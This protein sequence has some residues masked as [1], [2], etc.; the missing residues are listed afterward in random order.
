MSSWKSRTAA[1][2]AEIQTAPK[3][4]ATDTSDDDLIH[5]V[6]DCDTS[7]TLCGTDTTGDDIDPDVITDCVV[8]VDLEDYYD[9]LGTCCRI[10]AEND[11][12]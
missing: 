1:T 4:V 8:C 5:T 2:V 7:R 10:G 3:P 6:C 12:G 9:K 11:C